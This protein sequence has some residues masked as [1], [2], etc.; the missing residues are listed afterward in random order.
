MKRLLAKKKLKT[1]CVS[2]NK[3]IRKGEIYY[4]QRNIFKEDE[5]IYDRE[6]LQLNHLF[7]CL[8]FSALLLG[9]TKAQIH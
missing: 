4:K 7:Q 5:K 6:Y 2:C 1:R 3:E 9:I 8:N